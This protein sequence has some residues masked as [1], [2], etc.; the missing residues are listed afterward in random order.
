[1]DEAG[2]RRFLSGAISKENA[3]AVAGVSR[4]SRCE[5]QTE[6][7]DRRSRLATVSRAN[8]DDDKR[9][10][11]QYFYRVRYYSPAVGRFVSEDPIEFGAGDANFYRY[12][13]NNPSNFTDP[14]GTEKAVKVGEYSGPDG[15]KFIIYRQDDKAGT[16]Y[17]VIETPDGQ[18]QFFGYCAHTPGANIEIVAR[19]KQGN[20]NWIYWVNIGTKDI[21]VRNRIQKELDDI[22]KN[23]DL[24][25]DQRVKAIEQV[26]ERNKDDIVSTNNCPRIIRYKTWPE[27]EKFTWPVDNNGRRKPRLDRGYLRPTEVEK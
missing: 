19:D 12:V 15:V 11:G 16:L 17:G 18:R 23:K 3:P 9:A 10:M 27:K 5:R 22:G 20:V 26:L 8:P 7:S 4:M 14:S 21:I 2:E 25:S 24:N 1:M 13:A 6:T